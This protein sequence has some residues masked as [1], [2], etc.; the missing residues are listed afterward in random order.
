[1][2]ASLRS[3][4]AAWQVQPDLA[5]VGANPGCALLS[6]RI[7]A[8]ISGSRYLVE[9]TLEFDSGYGRPS[10]DLIAGLIQVN[11]LAPRHHR[12]LTNNAGVPKQPRRVII[13]AA[14]RMAVLFQ[15]RS[16]AHAGVA[17]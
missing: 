15:T 14:D 11:P 9:R 10:D 5:L 3:M 7:E 17:R 12:W 16:W 2:N 6:C 4:P 1:M 8:I 13:C